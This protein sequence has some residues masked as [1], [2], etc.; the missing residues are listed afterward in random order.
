MEDQMTLGSLF[1]GSGGFELAGTLAGVKPVFLSEVEPFCVRLTEKRFPDVKHY[2]DVSRLSGADLEP[3]DVITFGSPCFPEGTLILTDNGY[4][5]IEEVEVGMRVLTHKG[6][7]RTVTATGA[8]FGET[9]V[10]KGNHYGLECT[11]NHPIYSSGERK[12]YPQL[13]NGKRGN[14]ILLTDE[15]SW[16]PAGEMKGKLWGVPNYAEPLPI[17]SPSYLGTSWQKPMPPFSDELFYFVGRWLGDGWVQNK[18]RPGRPEG[19]TGGQICICDSYDKEGELREIVEKMSER[20]SVYRHR[21]AIRFTFTSKVFCEWLTDNFGRYAYGKTMPGWV[22]GMR[23][24]YKRSLLNGLIDSDGTKVQDNIWKINT[25]S[26]RLAESIRILGEMLGYS[27]TVFFVKTED[28]CVIEGRVVNQRDWYSVVL[29][30]GKKR[31]HLS[32][33]RQGWYRVRSVTQTHNTKPVYNLTVDEDN[34]YVADGIVVHNCQDLSIAGNRAGIHEGKRSSLF[35]QA[36][37]II[38]EM[39]EATNGKYPRYA[40]FENVAGAFS[41]NNGADFKAVLEAFCS[42]ENEGAY[43]PEP[44]KGKWP[45]AG[46]ILGDNYS[47]AWRLFDSKYFGVA[48]R[49]ERIYLVADFTGWSA[50]EILFKRDGVP[51][52]T[53]E[54]FRKREE[55]TSGSGEGAEASGALGVDGYNG[56]VSDM[57]STLGVN[58][59]MSTGR[60]G[61]MVLN[62]QGGAVMSVTEDITGT[63]RAPDH[64]HQPAVLEA[65][66]FC[67]EHSA[68]A[69]SIGYEE[70][71]SPTLRAGTVPAALLFENHSQDTRYKG[72]L[73]VA[74]PV[75]ANYGMGGNNQ[76]F[77]VEEVETF[78]VRL[79]SDGSKLQRNNVYPTSVARTLDTGG[80]APDSNQG[81]VAVCEPTSPR[82]FGICSKTSH[83]MLGDNPDVGFYEAETSRCL[84]QGSGSPTRNQ[85]GIVVV[86]GNGSRPSHKGDGYRESETMYTL[87]ATEQHAVAFADKAASLS[88]N[89]GPKGHSSQQLKNPEQNFVGEKIYHSSKN[90]YHTEFKNDPVV[91]TLVASDFKDPP[92]VTVYHSNHASGMNADFSEKETANTLAAS[93]YKDPPTVCGEPEYIVRRLTPTEC[94]RLQAL[95]DWW[96]DGLSDDDPSDEEVQRWIGIFTEF[97]EAMGK[98]VKPKTANQVRKWLKDPYSDSAVYKMAGNGITISV[99][100]FILSNIVYYAQKD[101]DTFGT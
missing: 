34:S 24:S 25:T 42:V 2:G 79:T 39:K 16:V 80:I 26:K 55:I 35:F 22:F 50:G 28:T 76:P 11:P 67:T 46:Y 36:I 95:P 72:P 77:V 13:D 78:D 47:L 31:K 60:N 86:E 87:N 40:I 37:R 33:D 8:K 52:Y 73:D 58:C 101:P 44:P 81:G 66:G 18:Q 56:A 83:G 93:D 17:A 74:Q 91:D 57:A 30:R 84:D 5:P 1:S 96:C 88:A 92:T 45:H 48:Q 51:W 99:A 9:V 94:L 29:T 69:R 21:T 3:V 10:L 49:R 59:G 19:H 41:S 38:K 43:I 62:D 4:I 23:E 100:Y 6:R 54:G 32:D 68:K 61:V 64:G 15:K 7:W 53:P 14:M 27:T 97:N 85:G 75:T 65:A 90:S 89:D 82:A 20:Y 71:K 70:E 63:L 12:Y 98:T